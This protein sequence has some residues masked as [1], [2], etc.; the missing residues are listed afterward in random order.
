MLT[1]RT[2]CWNHSRATEFFPESLQQILVLLLLPSI[3]VCTLKHVNAP[4]V[5]NFSRSALNFPVKILFYKATIHILFRQQPGIQIGTVYLRLQ[6]ILLLPSKDSTQTAHNCTCSCARP[7][8]TNVRTLS[9]SPTPT[10]QTSTNVPVSP[11]PQIIVRFNNCSQ[12]LYIISQCG[13][14]NVS[15]LFLNVVTTTFMESSADSSHVF[16][17][18]IPYVL[19]GIV[20]TT[21]VTLPCIL[22]YHCSGFA[23][24]S[25]VAPSAAALFQHCCH[26]RR[27]ES[28]LSFVL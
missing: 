19:S 4:D 9:V 8:C 6:L 16:Y 17:V 26:Q 18:T 3:H 27:T 7:C 28:F 23:S 21:M 25:L 5:Q 24:T 2:L 22:H 10:S 13:H 11:V 14:N 12:C 1:S 15:T 20:T